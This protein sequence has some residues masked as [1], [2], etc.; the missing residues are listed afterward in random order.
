MAAKAMFYMHL[1]RMTVARDV[2]DAALAEGFTIES[3]LKLCAQLLEN[4][5][6]P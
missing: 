5:P 6:I 4:A 3:G 1:A 2:R